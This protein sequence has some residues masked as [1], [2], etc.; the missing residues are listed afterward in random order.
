MIASRGMMCALLLIATATVFLS[1]AGGPLRAAEFHV[2][3]NGD[4]AGPGT[5]EKPFRTLAKARDAARALRKAGPVT[6]PITI[7][8]HEGTYW[9]PQPLELTKE[10][11]GTAQAP[12]ILQGVP[13]K[14]VWLS[15]GMPLPLK[16]FVAVEDEAV[17]RRIP[18]E[19]RGRVRRFVLTEDQAKQLSPEW[20]DTWWIP[21][22]HL[23]ALSELFADGRR[24]PMARWPNDDYTTFGD[25]VEAAD[26][27]G[28]TPAFKY[29]GDRPARWD[30]SQGV[31]LY[32]YWRRGYRA[33][34]VRIKS[35]DTDAH[36]I[37]LAARN[38]LGNLDDGGACRYC[39]VHV[40]EELDAPGE[41]YLDRKTRTLYV[42]PPGKVREG[43]LVLSVNP[44]SVVKVRD[45]AHIQF[46]DLGIECS[47]RDGLRIDKGTHCRVSSCEVRNVA[48]TG[49]AVSGMY[50]EIRGC[51]VHD[52]GNEAIA[53]NTGDR[54]KLVN[55]ASVVDNCHI[56][57]TNRIARAGS[58][59]LSI[60]GVGVIASHN[61]IHDTGYIAVGFI[62][63]DHTM[64]YNRIFRTNVES[65]E[66]GVFYTGRDWT[67]RGS[68]IRY[69]FI[70]HV[71]DS[72]EGC[73]SST[74]FVH[75]D[76]STPGIEIYGNVCYRLGG[77]VSICGGADN[78]VHDN[79][80]VECRWGV[81]VG[82]RGKDMFSSDG[83]G[84]YV[85]NPDKKNWSS[86]VK[87][88][89]RYKWNQPP[90]STRYPRLVEIFSKEPIA[91]PWFNVIE[92][93]VM[94]ACERGIREMGLQPGW[95][96]I[97]DNWQPEDPGFVEADHTLLDFRLKPDAPVV[98]QGFQP[99]PLDRIGLYGSVD[100]RTWPVKLD[101]PPTDWKPRWMRLRDAAGE[102]AAG[103]PIFKVMGVTG[104]I[105]I[106]GVVEPM[107]W[108]P[109][110]ATGSKPEI[111]DTAELDR[112]AGRK[113]AARP[114]QAMVQ[115]D[116]QN[117]YV[118]F[119]NPI[120]PK[121]GVT[122][123]HKWGADDAVEIALA[124]MDGK[125]LGPIIVLRGYTD[126]TW[127]SSP[128]AGA[129]PKTVER[130]KTGVK[131]AA[132]VAGPEFWSA[133]W[134]IPFAALGIDPR[135]RN[136]RLLF[137]LSVR[138]PAGNEWI[139]WSRGGGSTW[140][141]K[142]SGYLW[143]AQFGEMASAAPLKQPVGRIDID[144]RKAAVKLTPGSGCD[145]GTWAKPPGC[146]LTASKRTSP[147]P[148]WT[149][150]QF[151]FTPQSDGVVTLKLMGE[152]FEHPVTHQLAPVWVYM[153]DIRVD[154]AELTNGSLE[155]PGI[156]GCPH[157]WRT[158]GA[159]P[160]W[161][162]DTALA[163]SGDYCSKTW[164]NGRF[165]QDLTLQK[166]QPVTI[167]LKI[168]GLGK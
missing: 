131:Y 37:Y 34:F 81:D 23:A 127:E 70:H 44:D 119:R 6:E 84:G 92:R 18:K 17:R 63:N 48:A 118:C 5:E 54:Y 113:K 82:P 91:A 29:L 166:D 162:K 135:T 88:L 154:G 122:G 28:K 21:G 7:R 121:A 24:L 94:V 45:A 109:G 69:N 139:V 144:G 147:K 114:S 13:R 38:S 87:R 11:S 150:M 31:W 25:I 66:G 30:A 140:D 50:N 36:I 130:S 134:Q 75:L 33:E 159:P 1:L 26:E 124:V 85:V 165:A 86:L 156:K 142:Q 93:N 2:A 167:R 72:R 79:L 89:E 80:F 106:D 64:E 51:D 111:H 15:G 145:V 117:L 136:P 76:D 149:D 151:S 123:G 163:A 158:E 47:A 58:R 116:E 137:N 110:D 83:K 61:L 12:L 22:R 161:V 4:D 164:H 41:W 62:G 8:I 73:G 20:P 125:K 103:L 53:V 98:A 141:V 105:V 52:T 10:D 128:E 67:S 55:G 120:D 102:T 112:T 100:R 95:C 146:Y 42:Y 99:I 78:H 3:P 65:S 104:K 46:R 101:L 59:A 168:R 148:E 68:V 108:T 35:I 60:R 115:T 57:H 153:D 160:L 107:E 14:P 152:G 143:L 43:Q 126:G 49:I 133:E 71:D 19:A 129:D 32:G 9:L 155:A 40:L 77:G 97:K 138:K 96:T 27:E 16:A 90:Y 56:H 157:G 132:K 39:A 74:R